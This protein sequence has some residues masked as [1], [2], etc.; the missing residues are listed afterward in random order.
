MKKLKT[1][2]VDDEFPALKQLQ[3]HAILM[4]Q[5]EVIGTFSNSIEAHEFLLKQPVDLILSDIQMPQMN[6]IDLIQK[7]PKHCLVV[8]F[9]ANPSFALKAFDFNVLDY[10]VKPYT[11][12]RFNKAI[13]KVIDISNLTHSHTTQQYLEFKSDFL[14]HRVLIDHIKYIEGYGEYIKINTIQ[15]VYLVFSRLNDFEEKNKEK[16]FIRIHKS[17]IVLRQKIVSY[18]HQTVKLSD[19]TELPV[20][21]IFKNNLKKLE[22]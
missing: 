6:G 9:T 2:L 4:P 20:G 1:I 18:A 5:L 12:A 14:T 13:N 15:K 21:R 22:P 10:V 3:Q 7:I 11:A 16:G 8:F 17:Y 19:G